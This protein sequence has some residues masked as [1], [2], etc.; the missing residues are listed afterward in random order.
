MVVRL[1]DGP[2]IRRQ[3]PGHQHVELAAVAVD[4]DVGE[5]LEGVLEARSVLSTTSVTPGPG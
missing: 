3:L 4:A 2:G 1:E 5:R